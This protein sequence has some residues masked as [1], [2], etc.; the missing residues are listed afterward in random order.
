MKKTCEN[1]GHFE[2]VISK[3]NKYYNYFCKRELTFKKNCKEWKK[4]GAK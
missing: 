3:N 4:R 2:K 1:C